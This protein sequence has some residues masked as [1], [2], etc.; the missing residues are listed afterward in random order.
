MEKTTLRSDAAILGNA[1]QPDLLGR[2]AFAHRVAT[3]FL[4]QVRKEPLVISIEG[5]W[6]YGKTSTLN[7]I[8]KK[9]KTSPAEHAPILVDFNPWLAGSVES[10]VEQFLVQLATAIGLS[11]YGEDGKKAAKQLI[12][13]SGIFS[14]LKFVPGAEPWASLVGDILKSV[15]Q[16]T[17]TAS[18]LRK[19]SLGKRKEAAA[20]A[21]LNLDRPIVIFIDDLD[22][23]T[24]AEAFEMVRVIKAVADFPRVT[25]VLA[26]D[27]A[28]IEAALKKAGIDRAAE[29]L[30]KLIQVRL[31]LPV[32]SNRSLQQL[33]NIEIGRL[34][35][36]VIEPFQHSDPERLAW[37]Y[38]KGLARLIETPR[39]IN[40]IF[41]RL[42][43][44]ALAL[45]GEV[46]FADLFALEVL[47][48]KCPSVYECIRADPEYFQRTKSPSRTG[49]AQST[50]PFDQVAT[51]APESYRS[52]VRSVL[53]ELF[54]ALSENSSSD[55][56]RQLRSQ[57]RVAAKDRLLAAL[58][59]DIPIGGLPISGV[60][61]FMDDRASREGF[62][63][64]INGENIE[65]LFDYLDSFRESEIDDLQDY[66]AAMMRICA[67]DA[68][69]N[70]NSRTEKGFFLLPL[71]KRALESLSPPLERSAP[72]R[73][74]SILR[75]LVGATMDVDADLASEA[76]AEC[77]R[78]SSPQYNATRF[79]RVQ[80]ITDA[81]RPRFV[82]LWSRRYL[83]RIF[84]LDLPTR[85]ARSIYRAAKFVC[86]DKLPAT[87]RKGLATEGGIDRFAEISC[88]TGI[89]SPGGPFVEVLDE[90][91]STLGDPV[92]IRRRAER[93]LR[94]IS[95]TA[96]LELRS[97]LMS[98]AKGKKYFT[99]TGKEGR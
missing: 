86:P 22:R 1:A 6:G 64:L 92:W 44:S 78:Q 38:Y 35:K 24:P 39:D 90:E 77:Y 48:V 26:F 56:R 98:I 93:R 30:E 75:S 81:D 11:D 85:K 47:A 20:K 73:R 52:H 70:Y 57:G 10:L 84:D 72:D 74:K 62:I 17:A 87:F 43:L 95:R 59:F 60:L 13:Y 69:A 82:E 25:Y 3:D 53:K 63:A 42:S 83:S 29:Y 96:S 19:L 5:P 23:L 50:D 79:G 76:I 55:E 14:A 67:S 27:L 61:R 16:A 36:G 40:R 68:A 65:D 94:R 18:D 2:T 88:P 58:S 99:T 37:L 33:L 66:A 89:Q 41:N 97:A 91:L 28:H 15:G 46:A 49:S 21:L 9:L 12:G 31:T 71:A 80:W 32:I 51:L 7:L 8:K 54:P 45:A 4:L 34:P